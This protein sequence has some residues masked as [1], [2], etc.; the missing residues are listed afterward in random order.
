MV[1]RWHISAELLRGFIDRTITRQDSGR[2]VRHLLQGCHQCSELLQRVLQERGYWGF[3]ERA[4][5]F[6]SEDYDLAFQAARQ[7]TTGEQ[8]RLAE[9]RLLGWA[10]WASLESLTPDERL[11]LVVGDPQY[12]HWGL[13]KAL[14]DASLWYLRD[15]PMEA[16]DIVALA[17]EVGRRTDPT[18]VGGDRAVVDLEA[19]AWAILGNAQRVA[20]KLDEARTSINKAWE[21]HGQGTGD[22]LE[23]ALI[24]SLDASWARTMGEFEMA[25]EILGEALTVYK[26]L[27]DNHLQGR[28]LLQMGD[29][30]G[31]VFPLRGIAYI[32]R[33][34]ELINAAREP[35]LEL[36]A[37]HDLAWFLN[38][39]GQS[40]E[41]LAIFH[42]A[43][44]LYKQ[45]L[46]RWTQV[47]FHWIQGKIARGMGHLKGAVSIFQ[48]VQEALREG[49]ADLDELMVAID[50]S[51]A[52]VASGNY[53][54]AART[55]AELVPVMQSWHLHR[56]AITAW[57]IFQQALEARTAEEAL[58]T[59]LRSY[60]LRH[61]NKPTEEFT[62]T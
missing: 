19:R 4:A 24:L 42:R 45:F 5:G 61:W 54:S 48:Q 46:D 52:F 9:S 28:T 15:D 37:Q 7:F 14:L 3:L 21:L 35:R 50:L 58:I 11:P 55:A 30:I 6:N 53:A 36:C 1:E 27:Q 12:H 18:T 25:E 51:E 13:Y 38:D 41:A 23:K 43:R 40:T 62:A 20:S 47:R 26:K 49:G 39:A 8:R 17:I 34:L 16:M 57:L 32:R 10:Q 44:P 56:H 59:K 31:H 33:A 2:V 22:E 60:Y 29:A